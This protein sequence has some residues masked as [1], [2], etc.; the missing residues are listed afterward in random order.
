M[1][2]DFFRTTQGTGSCLTDRKMAFA[3][4]LSM[5]Q[6]IKTHNLMHLHDGDADIGR[7]IAFGLRGNQALGF[8]HRMQDRQERGPALVVFSDNLV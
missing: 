5:E 7:H 4:F 3:F 2:N 6:M 8:L 1:L